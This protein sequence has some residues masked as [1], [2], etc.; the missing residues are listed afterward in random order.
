[1]TFGEDF[2]RFLVRCSKN[3]QK[4]KGQIPKNFKLYL[5]IFSG[6]YEDEDFSEHGTIIKNLLSDPN[7][8]SPA[9]GESGEWDNDEWIK[10]GVK[11]S[12]DAEGSFNPTVDVSGIYAIIDGK[13]NLKT[14]NFLEAGTNEEDVLEIAVSNNDE[15]ILSPYFFEKFFISVLKHHANNH[16]KDMFNR[17][18]AY[19]DSILGNDEESPFNSFAPMLTGFASMMGMNV[20]QGEIEK[21]LPKVTGVMTNLASRPEIQG[22]LRNAVQNLQGCN[23]VADFLP[24]VLRVFNDQAFT[25]AIT[26]SVVDELGDGTQDVDEIVGKLNEATGQVEKSIDA[27]SLRGL[28]FNEKGKAAVEEDELD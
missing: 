22:G 4:E 14:G 8:I 17:R 27:E 9:D 25:R 2:N 19:I 13:R 20:P 6:D 3:L 24:Q 1:M 12:Y 28:T 5:A 21:T 10:N 23:N 7:F 16:Q 18:A 11:I 26:E 15:A